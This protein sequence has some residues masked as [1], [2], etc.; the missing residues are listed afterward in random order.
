MKHRD[1]P[2]DVNLHSRYFGVSYPIGSRIL[3]GGKVKLA[4]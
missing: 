1:K 2:Y 3:R 4:G